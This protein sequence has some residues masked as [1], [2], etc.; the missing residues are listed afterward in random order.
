[1]NTTL[2]LYSID[3]QWYGGVCVLAHSIEEAITLIQARPNEAVEKEDIHC[4]ALEDGLII[5]FM[6]DS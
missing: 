6:G 1:M 3:F 5:S 2:M 4:H